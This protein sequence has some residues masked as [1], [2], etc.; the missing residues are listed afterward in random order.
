MRKYPNYI[1]T[2]LF[3]LISS[4]LD[5]FA[6]TQGN[7]ILEFDKLIHNFGRISVNEGEKHCSFTYKNISQKPVVINNIITSCG[8]TTPTWSKKPIMPGESGKI[9]VTYLND[10]GP[11]PFDK[12][13]TVY[14]SGSTKPIVLRI[15]GLAYEKEKSLK[16][17]FP[18]SIG[19]LGIKNNIVK[20]GQITQGNSKEGVFTVAN[21]S[22]KSVNVSFT[23]LS[24]GL[25]LK[26]DNYTIAAGE[27]A[28]IYYKID[29]KTAINWGNTNYS[30]SVK[31][32]GATASTKLIVNCMIIDNFST[33]TKEQKNSA[34][35]II[36]KSSSYNFGEINASE[37][38]TATFELVNRGYST[39]KIY[40]IYDDQNALE[41]QAPKSVDASTAF[42]IK[43]KVK[44]TAKQ[45]APIYTITLVTN[46]PARPLVNLFITGNIK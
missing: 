33:L 13:L 44:N 31:C 4:S 30:A 37:P 27:V 35:M 43:A 10:Q 22:N 1:V 8:C 25:T 14:S 23:N 32:N 5:C 39:L 19:A 34:P 15:K 18:V 21:I 24:A 36:A 28:D 46:S 7:S 9:N 38:V 6:Q 40:R 41:I 12:A 16:D 11:Y 26:M 42:T 29:T 3:L 45:G 20:G 2:L 17:M